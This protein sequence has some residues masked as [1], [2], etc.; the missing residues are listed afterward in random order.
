MKFKS[1]VFAAAVAVA[2]F[3]GVANAAID[4]GSQ[5]GQ[6]NNSD[7]IL[8][9]SDATLGLGYV[10]VL[11]GFNYNTIVGSAAAGT[12]SGSFDLDASK[13]SIFSASNRD[14]MLWS[15]AV[16]NVNDDVGE[17]TGNILTMS[18][19]SP[20]DSGLLATVGTKFYNL[21]TAVNSTTPIGTGALAASGG[22]GTTIATE[23][24]IWNNNISFTF[25]VNTS[26]KPS[27]AQDLWYSRTD[28]DFA[29]VNPTI[30]SANKWV[31]DL[32]DLSA[33][34]LSSTPNVAAV[35]LPAAAWLM[36][37][38]LLGLGGIARRRQSKA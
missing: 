20:Q 15:M 31:L 17:V 36:I 37:T 14:N 34:T 30:A 1:H 12:F 2:S 8:V 19:A 5:V 13:L 32:G 28:V 11:D 18:A 38:S 6:S 9:I 23:S 10:Q 7:L 22:V 33:A 29:A 16:A 26:A 21:A 27:V 3:C 24:A 4:V 35:P 25:G